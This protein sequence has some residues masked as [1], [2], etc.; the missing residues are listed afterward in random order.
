[1]KILDFR[2][3]EKGGL[4]GFVTVE[5]PSGMIIHDV[6]IFEK[7]GET[8]ASPPRKARVDR[9]GRPIARD[10]KQLYAPMVSFKTKELRDKWSEA[11]CRAWECIELT[12]G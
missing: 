5:M 4:R 2:A 8:W 11:V 6:A 10:G 9:E 12:H 7:N 3:V 1:M